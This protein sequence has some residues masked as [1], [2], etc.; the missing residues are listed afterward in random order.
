VPAVVIHV[1]LFVLASVS[2]VSGRAMQT[3]CDG[4]SS[5]DTL[6]SICVVPPRPNPKPPK[7][8]P[9]PPPEDGGD[10][11]ASGCDL[12]Y[13]FTFDPATEVDVTINGSGRRQDFYDVVCNGQLTDFRWVDSPLGGTPAITAADIVPGVWVAVQRQLPTPVPRIAPADFDPDGFTFVQNSTFFWVDQVQ[14]QWAPVTGSASA[15]GITVS[16]QATPLRLIVDTGDGESVTCEGPP[17]AF[18][19]GTDPTTFR[20]CEHV[21]RKSS[22]MSANGHTFP[23][24]MTIEWSA[25]WSASTGEGGSLGARRTTSSPR[26]LA[27]AESLAVIVATGG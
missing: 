22:A 13:G 15:G 20:G 1:L 8:P 23:V 25:S 2:A 3:T 16:V 5:I 11:L 21:Y 9:A 4:H 6:Y 18:V 10:G 26:Q 24:T 12:V 17:P 19:E 14:G 7:T 27:V